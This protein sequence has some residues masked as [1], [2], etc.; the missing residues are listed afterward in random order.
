MS[1]H[2]L[3]SHL[4]RTRSA[5][6]AVETF[7]DRI[8]VAESIGVGITLRALADGAAVPSPQLPPPPRFPD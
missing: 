2:Q 4:P 3:L 6:P 5:R 7:E 1:R 8:P